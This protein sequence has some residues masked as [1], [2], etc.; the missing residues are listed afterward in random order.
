MKQFFKYVLA[1]IV[2]ML[3]VAVLLFLMGLATLGSIA[4]S[5]SSEPVVEDGSVLRLSLSGTLSERAVDDPFSS[6]MGNEALESQ[7]LDDMIKAI[8]VAKDNDKIKGIYIEGGIFSADF[9]SLQELRAALLDFKKSKKFVVAYSDNYLQGA[10]Y[11]A[12]TADKV[13]LNPSGM[14]DW[15]GIASQPIFFTEM[16]EKIGVKMQVFKVGTYKSAVEPYILTQMSDAN[17]EQVSSFVGDIW[18]QLLKDV[19]ASRRVKADSLNAYADRYIT[20]ANAGDYVKMHL[21][22]SLTYIDGVRAKL[23]SLSAQDE[24]KLVEVQDVAKLYKPA[25]SDNEVAVYYAEGDIVDEAAGGVWSSNTPQIV[26]QQVVADL[27][28]LADDDNVKAV[29]LRINSGGGSAYASEQMWRAVQLLKKKKPVVVSMS[30]MAASGGYYMSCGADYIVAEQTTLTGSIGI[31]GMVPDASGLLVDKLGLHFDVV[32][33]NEAADFGASGRPFSPAEAAA[34]QGYVNRGY[35]LFLSR[36]AAGRKMKTEEVD[37]IAQGRVWTGNQAL[38][39]KLVDKL[40]TLDDAVAEAAR[41]AK[42]KDYAVAS[43]PAQASWMDNLMQQMQGDDYLEQ[44]LQVSLGEYYAPLR[45]IRSLRNKR[46]MIQ[47]RIMFEPNF[48]K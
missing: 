29:V 7:G 34:M 11:I 38:K 37:R 9:A 21:V 28:K 36:V 41:R 19:A 25:N 43:Y 27:D 46:D 1:T 3:C 22:D 12:S 39:I 4:L 47:A 8:R 24:V 42:V 40:G 26:G 18:Q 44:K 15:R 16:L 31:F 23:R 33:T 48:V 6:F 2:G 45:F 30:G 13:L 14:V 17:R 35:A 5:S 10:Y 20:F 32:K